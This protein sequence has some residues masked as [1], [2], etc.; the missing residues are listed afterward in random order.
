MA[1]SCGFLKS[2]DFNRISVGNVKDFHILAITRR[3]TEL[4]Q[5]IIEGVGK[6]ALGDL[7]MSNAVK[8]NSFQDSSEQPGQTVA[9]TK[10]NWKKIIRPYLKPDHTKSWGQVLNTLPPYILCW[11]LSYQLYKVSYFLALP[12]ML[13][14]AL[15]TVRSFI[16]MHD[17]GHG[18]FFKSKRLRTLVGYLTGFVTFTPYHQWTLSHA[19]HHK[20]SGNLDKRGVGDVWTATVEEYQNMSALGKFSYRFYRH[21]FVTFFIGPFYIFM[22]SY[23]FFAKEDGPKE[24][25]SVIITN[26]Y[27]A[28][29]VFIM[30]SWLGW[31]AFLL[32]QFTIL[33]MAQIV[34]VW[35]FYV[36]HQYEGVYW[37][38]QE[39]WDYFDSAMLGSSYFKMPKFLQWFSGNIGYHHIHHLSHSIPNY[40]LEKVMQE[41]EIFQKPSTLTVAS[42]L[43]SAFLN[44][45]DE[46]TGDLISFREMKKRYPSNMEI[47]AESEAEVPEIEEV[48]S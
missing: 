36:Q 5:R 15:F 33:Q 28:A 16:I 8:Q 41:N 34:G 21:P 23:R 1:S 7:L 11:V 19:I 40:Y 24:K 2:S 17:C 10:E 47:E 30:G 35:F 22:I 43:K 3:F 48:F 18:S 20:H 46:K 9:Q 31:E 44:I 38:R 14:A 29:Y 4:L 45:Y 26:L 6:L 25:R 12:M 39:D 42:S 27:I 37:N 32:I 13:L